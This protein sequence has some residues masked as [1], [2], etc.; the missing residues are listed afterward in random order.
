MCCSGGS[1]PEP[2][3]RSV[4]QHRYVIVNILGYKIYHT[5]LE[6]DGRFYEVV[7]SG[8]EDNGT[9][10]KFN[11]AEIPEST[12]FGAESH[13]HQTIGT[14]LKSD[15]ELMRWTLKE[16]APGKEYD[17]VSRQEWMVNC[18]DY[19]RDLALFATDGKLTNPLYM[20]DSPFGG[21]TDY[22]SNGTKF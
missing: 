14:T 15:D 19:T 21:G 20:E 16:Y 1:G 7:A 8:P 13:S 18:Q 17:F 2:I 12:I 5:A 9:P 6:I 3:K 4:I 22:R 10:L 11:L